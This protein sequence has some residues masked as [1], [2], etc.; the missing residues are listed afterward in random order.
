MDKSRSSEQFGVRIG[1]ELQ[2]YLLAAQAIYNDASDDD[3]RDA[4]QTG[5]AV[6]GWHRAHPA[7]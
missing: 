4:A 3:L 5:A 6:G 2:R 1:R 7:G